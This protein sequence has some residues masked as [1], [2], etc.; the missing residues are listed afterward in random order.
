M[1]LK[2]KVITFRILYHKLKLIYLHCWHI[3]HD[4]IMAS[5]SC[6][7][8]HNPDSNPGHG[9]AVFSVTA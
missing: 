9:R 6:C 4:R 5:T 1:N 8:Q 7:G 2:E 3:V